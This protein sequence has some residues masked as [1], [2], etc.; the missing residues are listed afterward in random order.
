MKNASYDIAIIGGGASGLML[1]ANLDLEGA[2]GIVLEGSNAPGTKL[3]MSGGG[4][5]NFT[6]GGSIKDFINAYGEAGPALRKSL[7]RHNNL[8]IVKWMESHG[9]KS[10]DE[11]G[12]ILPASGRSKDVLDVLL[13]AAAAN[14]W[15]IKT[16]AKVI[17][18]R[19]ANGLWELACE[20]GANFTARNVVIATGGITYPET[21]SDGS[22]LGILKDL[23]IEIT[24]PRPALAPVYVDDYTYADLAGISLKDVSVTA[25]SSDAAHTCKGKAA[26]MT[27]DILFMHNGFS[28]PA[29]LNMSRY[30][31]PGEKIRFSYNRDFEDLPKRMQRVLKDRARGESGDV[32][33]SRLASILDH[34]DFTVKAVD[35][36]GM[37]TAGG[38][39]LDEIDMS[40]MRAKR[41]DGLYVIGEALDADG[42]TGGYNLQM[43]WSTACTCADDIRKEMADKRL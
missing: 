3:L 9:V 42:I 15:Q 1:A 11:D 17:G 40:T 23:G 2:S 13:G 32:K 19:A 22:M 14:H 35:K 38:V 12:R 26:R 41:F 39:L 28:G 27:G 20:N 21:G 8:E 43:C 30:A 34:D 7:Y 29:V 25:F 18:L 24:D 6:H 5:C 31:E 37:V 10:S 36:R 33:T 16:G 4:R